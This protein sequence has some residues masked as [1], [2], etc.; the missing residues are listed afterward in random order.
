MN[1]IYL[2]GY[3]RRKARWRTTHPRATERKDAKVWQIYPD[4]TVFTEEQRIARC[5]PKYQRMLKAW[6]ALKPG[7]GFM[8]LDNEYTY[9]RFRKLVRWVFPG[10]LLATLVDRAP[11][12]PSGKAGRVRYLFGKGEAAPAT[13]EGEAGA[14]PEGQVLDGDSEHDVHGAATAAGAPEAR[15]GDQ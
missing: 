10:A 5:T 4:P 15:R 7:E 1:V 13:D 8:E 11:D 14:V 9:Y 6:Q 2:S 3:S 12:S